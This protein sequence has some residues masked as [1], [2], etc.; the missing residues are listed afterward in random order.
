MQLQ[1]GKSLEAWLCAVAFVEKETIS[2]IDD[3]G[4]VLI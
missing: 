4:E 2:K 1:P 3:Q